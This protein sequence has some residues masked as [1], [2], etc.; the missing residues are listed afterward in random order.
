MCVGS[1]GRKRV[2]SEIVE[3]LDKSVE[4][5]QKSR[6]N[7]GSATETRRPEFLHRNQL[8]WNKIIP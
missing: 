1:E 2:E 6:S 3:S 5:K 4:L 8:F 7:S